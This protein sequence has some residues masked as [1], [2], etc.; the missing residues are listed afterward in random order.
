MLKQINKNNK[1]LSKQEA[2]I[3]LLLAFNYYR[4]ANRITKYK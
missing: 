1:N 4:D 3:V 2:I